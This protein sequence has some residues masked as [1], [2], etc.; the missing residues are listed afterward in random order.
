MTK[1]KHGAKVPAKGPRDAKIMIVGESPGQAET[2]EGCPFVGYVGRELDKLLRAAG[3]NRQKCY[4]TYACKYERRGKNKEKWFWENGTFGQPT[5]HFIE[6]I[7]ELVTDV[8]E[9]E[10]YAIIALGNYALWALTG[11][12]GITNWRGSVILTDEKFGEPARK[13]IPSLRPAFIFKSFH[14]RPLLLWDLRKASTESE[15]PDLRRLRRDYII[16]PTHEQVR[17][18]INRLR[19]ADTITFDSE[20]YSPARVSCIGFT[21][22]RDWAIC[23]PAEMP[24]AIDAYNEILGGTQRK[25]AQNAMFDVVNLRRA[26]IEVRT[27]DDAG[28]R[29]IEDTMVAFHVCWSDI[30]QKDLGT[31][32]SL[33]TDIPYYKEDLKIWGE[34]G[35][36][37]TL[38]RYN[39]DDNAGTHESWEYLEE[40]DLPD[41]GAQEAYDLSMLTFNIM[42]DS[43]LFGIR[44]DRDLFLRMRAHHLTRAAALQGA[45]DEAVGWEVNP[46]STKDVA[47]LVYDQL[48]VKERAKRTTRQEVLLDIAA[49]ATAKGEEEIAAVITAILRIRQNLNIVSKYMGD[50]VIDIDGRIRCNWNMAGTK[51]GRLSASKTYWGSGLPIQQMT[52]EMRN[53][54]VADEGHVFVGHDLAQ[55]EA[56][57]VAYLSEDYRI[58]EWLDAGIDIH[59]MTAS[60]F[61]FG[62]TYEEIVADE[63]AAVGQSR[64]RYAGK[65]ARHALNYMMGYR[66]FKDSINK[67]YLDTGIGVTESETKR[68]RLDYLA[69]HP[70]LESVWWPEV[71]NEVSKNGS[72]TNALGRRKRFIGRWSDSMLREAVAYYPQSTVADLTHL[73]ISRCASRLAYARVLVNM[74]DG[75]LIQ[76]PEDKVDEALPII[77]ECFTIPIVVKGQEL[78]I[79]VDL[80]MGTRWGLLKKVD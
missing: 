19:K 69:L 49:Q 5:D 56:R 48:G 34:T 76:I 75:S 16:W 63:A 41:C 61:S 73:G 57:V 33:Y 40:K 44:A 50:D 39:C 21:D 68:W 47:Y 22:T 60:H 53:I 74:H 52:D 11:K 26:G 4:I 42:A 15:Y 7:V 32:T 35:D 27:R 66:T 3:I 45:L 25:V 24:G 6:G 77:R 46:R 64:Y 29:L 17:E 59:S 51:T 79:P 70:N 80:K 71:K 14:K 67:E 2:R 23:I 43:T 28:E 1:I 18:A 20:W 72:I 36:K 37:D 30:G 13:V 58:L 31:L 55:A 38:Y 9:I 54:F 12:W 65:K 8:K 62:M 78:T 10:P